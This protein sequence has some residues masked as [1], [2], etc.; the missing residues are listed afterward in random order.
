MTDIFERSLAPAWGISKPFNLGRF[1]SMDVVKDF[2]VDIKE[3][4]GI[5]SIR[6][7]LPGVQKE[8]L[9][10]VY[11]HNT[12][13][14]KAEKKYEYEEDEGSYIRQESSYGIMQRSFEVGDIEPENIDASFKDGV[15]TISLKRSNPTF[16]KIAIS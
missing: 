12:L 1:L 16:K 15:L 9:S 8:N 14:I 4:G 10:V 7:E 11:E 3:E 5:I 13:I 2:P 6:A